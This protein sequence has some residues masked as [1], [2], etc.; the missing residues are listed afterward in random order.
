MLKE[1][2]ILAKSIKRGGYC[3]AGLDTETG[4]WIRPISDNIITEGAVPKM[5]TI[6]SNREEL[7]IFDKVIIE[8]V[9]HSPTKAQPENYV[10]DSSV[11]WEKTGT[12]SLR[13]VL[14]FRGYDKVN[15]I[16]YNTE[17]SVSEEEV[18]GQPSLLLLNVNNPSILIKTFEKKKIQ[19]NFEYNG[20]SYNFFQVGD[21]LVRSKYMNRVDG[22]YPYND[23]VDVVFSL[24]D[25]Y[26]NTGRYYKMVAQ[27]FC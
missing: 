13:Q 2:I 6:L 9:S 8:L 16:F 18:G 11:A 10:Y 7:K 12:S 4:E 19:F 20:C 22:K 21:E 14:E 26:S 5:D 25:K 23:N 3:I 27:L 24:T 17:K 15:K 1:I